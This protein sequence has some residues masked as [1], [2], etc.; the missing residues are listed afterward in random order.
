VGNAVDRHVNSEVGDLLQRIEEFSGFTLVTTNLRQ[1]IDTAFLRRFRFIVDFPVPS[2]AERL[3]LWRSA[4]PAATP[5]DPLDWKHLVGLPLTGGSIRNVAL[6]AAFLAAAAGTSVTRTMIE[7][8]LG[9]EMRK[10]DLPMPRLTW[11]E[12]S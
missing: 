10:Q 9:H 6:G 12:Q 3:R 4:F 1:A 8:E 5:V 11:S 7:S 2:P